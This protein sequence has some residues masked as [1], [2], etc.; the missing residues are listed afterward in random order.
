MAAATNARRC[1]TPRMMIPSFSRS[2]SRVK[3]PRHDSSCQ[4]TTAVIDE[5]NDAVP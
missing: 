4:Q 1:I 3:D 2:C 5:Q